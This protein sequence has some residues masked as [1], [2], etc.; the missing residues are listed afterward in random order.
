MSDLAKNAIIG[1]SKNKL[2]LTSSLSPCA[3][4]NSQTIN[5]QHEP[6]RDIATHLSPSGLDHELASQE[7]WRAWLQ[8]PQ[9]YRLVQ[10]VAG[11][12]SPV[13][14]HRQTEGLALCV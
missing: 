3:H 14:E 12:H 8:R 5:A 6:R 7:R 13:V 2:M 9:L 11:D 4:H 10:R 1:S